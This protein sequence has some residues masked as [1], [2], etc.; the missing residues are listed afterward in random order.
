MLSLSGSYLAAYSY[1]HGG[2]T[3]PTLLIWNWEKS[4]LVAQHPIPWAVA[5]TVSDKYT[6]QIKLT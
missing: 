6:G 5:N 1:R 2:D 4:A 3:T